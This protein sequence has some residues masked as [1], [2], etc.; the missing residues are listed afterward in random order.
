MKNFRR[1]LTV[2]LTLVAM[3]ATLV[4]TTGCS[5]A[6]GKPSAVSADSIVFDGQQISWGAAKGAQS[7]KVEVNGQSFTAKTTALAYATSEASITVEITS[8]GR[9]NKES[10][11]VSKT[12]TKLGTVAQIYFDEAGVATWD[13]VEGATSYDVD[14]N[15]QITSVTTCRFDAFGEGVQRIRVR[16]SSVNKDAYA[17]WSDTVTKTFLSAPKSIK[18]EDGRISW[19]AVNEAKGYEVYINGALAMTP[20]TTAE[21]FDPQNTSFSVK[22]KALGDKQNSFDSKMSEEERYVFLQSIT[23]ETFKVEAGAIAWDPVPD[24]A[25]Y[26]IKLTSAASEITTQATTYNKLSAGTKYQISI[27]PV[28]KSSDAHVHYFSSWSQ[29]FPVLFLKS[30]TTNWNSDLSLEDGNPQRAFGWDPVEGADIASFSVKIDNLTNGTSKVIDNIAPTEVSVEYDFAEVGEYEISVQAKAKAEVGVYD[31]AFSKPIKVVRLNPPS[32]D[33][34]NFIQSTANNLDAGF[35]VL[36]KSDIKATNVKIYLEGAEI[37][38][39]THGKQVSVPR[40]TNADIPVAETFTYSARSIGSGIKYVGDQMVVTLN[41]LASDDY[42]FTI[43]VQAAPKDFAFSGTTLTWTAATSTYGFYVEGFT[44]D[45]TDMSFDLKKITTPGAR[46]LMV[47]T[48]GN[49]KDIL[50][51]TL[52]KAG[53]V[54]KLTRPTELK[55]IANESGGTLDWSHPLRGKGAQ[56]FNAYFNGSAEAYDASTLNNVAS[57]VDTNS[58]RIYVV[59]VGEIMREGT[60]VLSSEAS[61]VLSLTKLAEPTFPD[62]VFNAAETHLIW[63]APLG[64]N[65]TPMY[66]LYDADTQLAMEGTY[67]STQYPLA[68]L[69]PGTYTFRVKAIGNGTSTINSELSSQI[70]TITILESPQVSLVDG[71]FVWPVVPAAQDYTVMIGDE[72]IQSSRITQD[73]KGNFVFT[74]DES[75]FKTTGIHYISF[76]ATSQ[77]DVDSQPTVINQVV[78]KLTQPTFTFSYTSDHFDPNEK[79]VVEGVTQQPDLVTS[80]IFKVGDANAVP[81]NHIGGV[82]SYSAEAK[83]TGKYKISAMVTGG[84]FDAEG[85]YYVSSDYAAEKSI[86]LLG[87]PTSGQ[88]TKTQIKWNPVVSAVQYHLVIYNE[89]GVEIYNNDAISATAVTITGDAFASYNTE[90]SKN[91][92]FVLRAIGNKTTII[93]SETIQWVGNGF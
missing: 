48:K 61:E 55:L 47:C 18:Y 35:K 51:S 71:S 3:V 33:S 6:S 82:A 50:P 11:T 43:T 22:V 25:E 16:A 79:I 27:K 41:S 7:Y 21:S 76:K 36:F 19:I 72:L 42:R 26:K 73:G 90:Q 39:G 80:F 20:T 86:T 45:P 92:T 30:P 38:K 75:D 87:Q 49:G 74:P 60:Y 58:V 53:D 81:V 69:K 37:A 28:G 9:K 56:S 52:V 63:N 88:V 89:A 83:Y 59:A 91:Y 17:S 65:T 85:A 32:P 24:A 40:P 23:P 34:S 57:M 78:K 29:E 4:L 31:S 84:K 54:D 8:V 70:A 93:D 67:S 1:I 44:D 2:L 66:M 12:F 46:T 77:S 62:K 64:T 15:G 5:S 10:K 14:V 13:P 68:G